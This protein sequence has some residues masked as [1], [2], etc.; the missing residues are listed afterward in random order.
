M[1]CKQNITRMHHCESFPSS[2]KLDNSHL[3]LQIQSFLGPG[4]ILNRGSVYES[5]L[6]LPSTLALRST[7]KVTVAHP[8]GIMLASPCCLHTVS[9]KD[10]LSHWPR[11]LYSP[12]DQEMNTRSVRCPG[13]AFFLGH[14][15]FCEAWVH[16]TFLP[17]C[18][19]K[20]KSYLSSLLRWTLVLMPVS[21]GQLHTPPVP[22]KLR[23][24]DFLTYEFFSVSSLTILSLSSS[25][26]QPVRNVSPDVSKGDECCL[27]PS[28]GKWGLI[29]S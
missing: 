24:S 7:Y 14:N 20:W 27:I 17:H 23:N 12:E 29:S 4:M 11:P 1:E 16:L 5:L 2:Y 13:Q 19:L 8:M 26:F 15:C 6:S 9:L 18:H 3:H 22:P 25:P 28:L 10:H 21:L